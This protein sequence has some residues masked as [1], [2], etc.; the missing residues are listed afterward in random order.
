[1][2]DFDLAEVMLSG[3]LGQRRDDR[4]I[5][6]AGPGRPRSDANRLFQQVSRILVEKTSP[7]G[8]RSY[9]PTIGLNKGQARVPRACTHRDSRRQRPSRRH[10]AARPLSRRDVSGTAEV[11]KRC[12][13]AIAESSACSLLKSVFPPAS[14]PNS[15][16][17]RTLPVCRVE[18]STPAATPERGFSTL[19]N[20][21]EVSGAPA[22]PG[23]RRPQSI[24]RTFAN[25]SSQ[26]GPPKAIDN[27]QPPLRR[28]S[29]ER[30]CAPQHERR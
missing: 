17:P 27:R 9:S 8:V 26:A 16:T 2:F 29:R 13:G 21:V 20:S 25:S 30:R 6:G 3:D 15:A 23:R 14:D 5:Q 4:K 19:P 11:G 1:M 12:G 24:G 28:W 22:G 10:R 18:L 7:E